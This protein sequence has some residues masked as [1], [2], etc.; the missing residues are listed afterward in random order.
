[1]NI[2][3]DLFNIDDNVNYAVSGLNSE[4]YSLYI[5]NKF[6]KCN[7]SMIVVTNSLY[8][9]S[10]LFDK[11]SDFSNDVVL[12]PMDDFLTSEATI[13]SPELMIERIN[14]LD[15]I[16]K[17]EKVILITNLMGYLRYL[18]NKK[19]WLKSYIELKKGMSID[20]E[21][22]IN[23]LYNSGYERETI[24]NESGKFGVRGYVI[25]IFPTLD[26]NPVRIE[27]W[28]DTIESIKYFDVQS[29]LSNKE[30][31]CVLIPP[32]SEFIVEDK[33][34]DVIKKQ[35]YLLH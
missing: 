13:I 29:Q 5:Y 33:N 3:D 23:K 10:N 24:V 26:N 8:E 25:D 9:A 12:F 34:I 28:G 7:K 14:T 35:K 15:S 22:L 11:I 16:C 32:F 30:I 31:D 18:P 6:K 27:F 20:R 21:L 2:F 1:M 17:K 19:L 4:L